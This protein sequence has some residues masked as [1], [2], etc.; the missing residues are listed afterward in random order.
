MDGAKMSI[1]LL[2]GMDSYGSLPDLIGG[3][4]AGQRPEFGRDI[5]SSEANSNDPNAVAS[6]QTGAGVTA[7]TGGEGSAFGGNGGDRGQ[8]GY[9][10]ASFPPPPA[11]SGRGQLVDIAA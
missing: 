2:N 6:A 7:S 3:T 10:R 1:S 4:D 11:E 9:S 8:G 5:L